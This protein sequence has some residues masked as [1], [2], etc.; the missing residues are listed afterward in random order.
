MSRKQYRMEWLQKLPC[1]QTRSGQG[2]WH[3][4]WALDKLKALIAQNNEDSDNTNHWLGWRTVEEG[5]R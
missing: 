1:G 5:E 4:A 3:E 2:R